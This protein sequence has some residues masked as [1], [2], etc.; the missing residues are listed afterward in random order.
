MDGGGTSGAVRSVGGPS[1][2]P[3]YRE[4]RSGPE[5]PDIRAADGRG[6]GP[7]GG[8]EP[9]PGRW[10]GV[11]STLR[12]RAV[13][14]SAASPESRRCIRWSGTP[15]PWRRLDP[16]RQALYRWGRFH[17]HL[18]I[19]ALACPDQPRADPPQPGLPGAR[20]GSVHARPAG[21]GSRI[22]PPLSPEDT[23]PGCFPLA[24][25]R[26][27]GAGAA[28]QRVREAG[29]LRD[30]PGTGPLPRASPLSGS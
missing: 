3:P 17:Q 4:R 14:C 21:K 7:G 25:N 27:A 12:P 24:W 6:A 22:F 19:G 2:M 5:K 30:N 23:S 15:A 13:T 20:R 26:P 11:Q 16:P 29:R 10:K 1:S 18:G 8:A 28:T 9:A